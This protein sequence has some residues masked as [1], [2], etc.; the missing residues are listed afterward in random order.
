MPAGSFGLRLRHYFPTSPR[1]D[2]GKEGRRTG[3]PH[4]GDRG[5]EFLEGA[6]PRGAE[7][8]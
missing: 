1:V 5:S 7:G 2:R 8:A 6:G 3:I 4:R